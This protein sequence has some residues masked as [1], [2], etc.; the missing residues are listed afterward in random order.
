MTE[1]ARKV[2]IAST[3]SVCM[4][5]CVIMVVGFCVSNHL[6]VYVYVHVWVVGFGCGCT[7]PC[8]QLAE[9]ICVCVTVSV[10]VVVC[11][12]VCVCVSVSV[13]ASRALI[14]ASIKRD[15]DNP[16]RLIL[17]KRDLYKKSIK[18]TYILSDSLCK[19]L[20]TD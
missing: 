15:L 14:L 5:L 18:Q 1:S 2:P 3:T 7:C 16:K 9:C 10:A 13:R 20:S 19:T 8:E 12:C 4:Y 11:V 6:C 17:T